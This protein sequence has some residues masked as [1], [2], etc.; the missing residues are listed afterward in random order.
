MPE[1]SAGICGKIERLPVH[2]WECT[3]R[4]TFAG[5]TSRNMRENRMPAGT[6]MGMYWKKDVRRKYQPE[7]VW[8]NRTPA[9]TSV[10]ICLRQDT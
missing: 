10:R 6:P 4:K 7:Y 9:G 3:G 1:I 8:E 5:N 2:R